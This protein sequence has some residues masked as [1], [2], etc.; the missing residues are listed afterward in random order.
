MYFLLFTITP[1][2]CPVQRRV[3]TCTLPGLEVVHV[4]EELS[5]A[6]KCDTIL[7]YV[8]KVDGCCGVCEYHLPEIAN[9]SSQLN[10]QRHEG[11]RFGRPGPIYEACH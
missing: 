2:R 3:I 9:R 8:E 11:I 10:K 5:L 7:S 6:V 4:E 1:K